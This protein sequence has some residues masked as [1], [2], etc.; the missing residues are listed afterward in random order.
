MHMIY[1]ITMKICDYEFDLDEITELYSAVGWT[2][3]TRDPEFLRKAFA[4]SLC[5]LGA[6]EDSGLAGFIRAVGD[7]ASILYIQDIVVRSDM[8]RKGIGT[9]LVRALLERYPDVYQTVLMTDDTET[10]VRFYESL[11]FSA[12]SDLNC[13]AF[14]KINI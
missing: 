9:A 2:N 6:Y 13:K 4:G 10:S 1:F 7:G 14:V 12:V 3:Y 8:Q 5:V 11:G